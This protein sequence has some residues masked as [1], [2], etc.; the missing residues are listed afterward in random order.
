MILVVFSRIPHSY[1]FEIY[2][3]ESLKFCLVHGPTIE[4]FLVDFLDKTC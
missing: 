3:A 4:T 2:L 1:I